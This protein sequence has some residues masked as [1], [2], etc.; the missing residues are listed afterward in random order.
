MGDLC[1]A[2]GHGLPERK[3]SAQSGRLVFFDGSDF[4]GGIQGLFA[5]QRAVLSVEVYGLPGCVCR[6]RHCK[7]QSDY[8]SGDLL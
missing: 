8:A 6:E 5:V 3:A 2:S 1:A 4:A 7:R